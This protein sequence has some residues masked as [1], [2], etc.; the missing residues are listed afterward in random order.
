MTTVI[1]LGGKDGRDQK[2]TEAVAEVTAALN[3]ARAQQHR[4]VAFTD[5][6]SNKEI[7]V[8]PARVIDVFE[9]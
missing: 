2:V 9:E 1:R 8:N 7:S 4:F 6:G 5:A 3:V